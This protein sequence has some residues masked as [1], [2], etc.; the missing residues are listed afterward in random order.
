LLPGEA[1]GLTS[2]K[3]DREHLPWEALTLHPPPVGAQGLPM[4]R[5]FLL[6]FWKQRVGDEDLIHRREIHPLDR[7]AKP[8][9]APQ[10]QGNLL[11]M[12]IDCGWT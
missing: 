12:A 2:G 8:S 3:L 6:Q 5:A 7:P 11:K 4:T 10:P 1:G 9:T